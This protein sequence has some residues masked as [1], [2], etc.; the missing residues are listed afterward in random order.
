M[1]MSRAERALDVLNIVLSDVRYGLGAYLG[2]YLLTEH[3]C[4]T[5]Q[6]YHIGR[7]EPAEAISSRTIP[8]R[9]LSAR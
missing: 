8:R 6:G 5:A 9:A 2:V 3:G 1:P 7:P 4:D